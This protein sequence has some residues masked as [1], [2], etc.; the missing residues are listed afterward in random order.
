MSKLAKLP[1]AAALTAIIASGTMAGVEPSP[2]I[3][4]QGALRDLVLEPRAA[5]WGRRSGWS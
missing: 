1:F 3:K 4:F 5:R 2:F